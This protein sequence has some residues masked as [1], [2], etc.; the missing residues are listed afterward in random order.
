LSRANDT[1]ETNPLFVD[2]SARDYR[3]PV[4]SSAVDVRTTFFESAP[5][6]GAFKY[7]PGENI[8][9][10]GSPTGITVE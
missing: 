3:L 9:P 7:S 1:T 10:P 8:T 2:E 4:L 5:G 6:L